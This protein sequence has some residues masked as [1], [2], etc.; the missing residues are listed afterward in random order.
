[1]SDQT[2]EFDERLDAAD[3]SA[4]ESGESDLSVEQAIAVLREGGMVPSRLVRRKPDEPAE[5]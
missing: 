3:P 2:H 1:M 4:P 5:Q